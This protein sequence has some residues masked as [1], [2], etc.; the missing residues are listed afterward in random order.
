[1]PAK[2]CAYSAPK[3]GG[4]PAIKRDDVILCYIARHMVWAGLLRVSGERYQG[5]TPL[6]DGGVFPNRVPVE[7]LIVLGLERAVPMATLEGNLTFFPKGSPNKT[8]A[9]YLQKSPKKLYVE[10]AE[11]IIGALELASAQA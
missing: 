6:Y 9:P 8:W 3:F 5:V 1:M 10:D 4:F 11:A 7:P 2:V